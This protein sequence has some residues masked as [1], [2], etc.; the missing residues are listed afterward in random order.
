MINL[1]QPLE[2]VGTCESLYMQEK[3]CNNSHGTCAHVTVDCNIA[4]LASE[5]VDDLDNPIFTSVE[6]LDEEGNTVI[7]EQVTYPKKNRYFTIID[8][9]KQLAQQK[10]VANAEIIKEIKLLEATITPRRLREAILTGDTSF[11]ESVEQQINILRNS[12]E[13]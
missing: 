6:Q 7:V 12:L 4:K 3:D 13:E 11:I 10:A 8:E 2:K 9:V 5:E 1:Y